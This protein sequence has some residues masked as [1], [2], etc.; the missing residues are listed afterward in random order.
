M[1]EQELLRKLGIWPNV[2]GYQFLMKGFEMI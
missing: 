2:R 1:G